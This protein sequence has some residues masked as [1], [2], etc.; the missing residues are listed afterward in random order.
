MEEQE[1]AQNICLMRT[2]TM[3]NTTAE[4][5]SVTCKY[6]KCITAIACVTYIG[7]IESR[8][9]DGLLEPELRVMVDQLFSVQESM[10]VVSTVTVVEVSMEFCL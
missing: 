5:N 10:S 9:R 2:L 1:L 3:S 4:Y 6:L 8:L 7:V